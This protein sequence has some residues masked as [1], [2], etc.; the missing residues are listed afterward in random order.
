MAAAKETLAHS[1]D[2]APKRYT[3]RFGPFHL[4]PLERILKRSGRTVVLPAKVFDT[5]VALVE[6]PGS[7]M[8]NRALIDRVWPG[9]QGDETQLRQH[10]AHLRMVLDDQ[11]RVIEGLAPV[12]YRFLADI[13][14]LEGEPPAP[15][16]AVKPVVRTAPPRFGRGTWAAAAVAAVSLA[17]VATRFF[18]WGDEGASQLPLRS[19]AVAP[20]SAP[21]GDQAV[22]SAIVSGLVPRLQSIPG[23]SVRAGTGGEGVEAVLNGS[24]ERSGAK[25]VTKVQLKP[26]AGGAEIFSETFDIPASQVFSVE[27]IVA[28]RVAI[29][30]RARLTPAQEANLLRLPTQNSEAYRLYSQIP[31]SGDEKQRIAALEKVVEVDP[32]FATAHAVLVEGYLAGA[33]SPVQVNAELLKKAKAVAEKTVALDATLAG[34][35]V[36]LG[37]A[38]LYLDWDAASAGKAAKR[39]LELSPVSGT[40][41]ALNALILTAQSNFD[42]AVQEWRKTPRDSEQTRY[43]EAVT[44]YHAKRY[45]R[46]IEAF[47]TSLAGAN[48]PAW[49]VQTYGHC[50]LA[51]GREKDAM[52][53][54][55]RADS[56]AGVPGRPAL[57][58]AYEKE[59]LEGYWRK[60]MASRGRMG[61]YE[62][63]VALM[64]TGKSWR[65]FESLQKAVKA[66]SPELVLAHVDPVMDPIRHDERFQKLIRQIGIAK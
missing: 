48:P 58:K 55:F 13:E 21:G 41:H 26:V 64:Q 34:P 28:K 18:D 45:D 65:A 40:A 19:I 47:Q 51:K 27:P 29:A 39:A 16:E 20:F 60:K 38:S 57:K 15:L 46:A 1:L 59:G 4:D 53:A 7:P 12:G 49:A 23:M 2:T 56:I 24:L 14:R 37:Y 32:E 35:H 33:I 62:T 25:I 36:A 5:L 17:F 10:M 54:Y 52:E 9:G 31:A 44:E 30:L 8:E 43:G 63:A 61:P 42:A 50:L 11:E 3:Y 22:A 6:S 66:R